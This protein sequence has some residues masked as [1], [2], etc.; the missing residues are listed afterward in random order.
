MGS[1]QGFTV[2]T[3]R[4]KQNTLPSGSALKNHKSFFLEIERLVTK[5][6]NLRGVNLKKGSAGVKYTRKQV[7][8]GRPLGVVSRYFFLTSIMLWIELGSLLVLG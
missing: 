5:S 6:S 2:E 8:T 4:R 3:I 1:V 7:D